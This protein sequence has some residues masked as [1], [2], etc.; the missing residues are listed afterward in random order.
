[1]TARDQLKSGARGRKARALGERCLRSASLIAASL[2]CVWTAAAQGTWNSSAGP[3]VTSAPTV[4]DQQI[5][6]IDALM[7]QVLQNQDQMDRLRENYA[8][9]DTRTVDTLDKQG[10]VKKTEIYLLQISFLGSLE[11]ERTIDKNGKLLSAGALKKEDARLAKKIEDYQRKGSKDNARQKNQAEVTVEAFL[12]AD[13]FYNPRREE[14]AGEHLIVFDFAANPEY[15]AKTL[16]EK[17]AQALDGTIWI[18]AHA[19]EVARL[20]AHLA[21]TV[22]VGGGLLGSLR[23][24]SSVSIIQAFVGHEVWL[25]TYISVHISARALLLFG[26]NEDQTDRYSAYKKFRVATHSAIGSQTKL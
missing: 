14:S 19:H 15:E 10:R 7:K 9:D 16:A 26:L 17:L 8:C 1:M 13:R 2:L 23:E 21:K 4:N 11:L 3:A 24:G 5:P 6:S 22:K 25:P 20:D 18:D 12:R